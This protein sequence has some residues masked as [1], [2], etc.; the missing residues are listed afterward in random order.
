MQLPS[1]KK[2]Y[3][4]IPPPYQYLLANA[5]MMKCPADAV[6]GGCSLSAPCA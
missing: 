1:V 4:M 5:P 6:S 2:T 3:L